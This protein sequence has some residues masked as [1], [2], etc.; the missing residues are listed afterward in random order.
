MS[1]TISKSI[2]EFI[3]SLK[4]DG[5]GLIPAVVQDALTKE[6]LMVGVMTKRAVEKTCQTGRVTF[7][8]RTK[9]RLWTKGETSGYFLKVKEIFVDCDEDTLLV[10]ADPVGP[11]CH[12]GAP[13]CFTEF[14]GTMR[15]YRKEE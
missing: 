2:D 15:R 7:W 10:M 4:Y 1:E 11:T 3:N 14:D 13:T 5:S 6:V 9:R 8:S 12:T